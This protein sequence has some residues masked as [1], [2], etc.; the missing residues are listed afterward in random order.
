MVGQDGPGPPEKTMTQQNTNSTSIVPE[1]YFGH[2]ATQTRRP[3]GG[4][5]LLQWFNA[6]P[7]GKI[8]AT[9]WHIQASRCDEALTAALRARAVPR[10]TVLH[11]MSGEM[12]EYWSLET[13]SLLVLCNGFSDPWEMRQS[14][15]RD[16]I[17]YGWIKA[18]NSS[19]MKARVLVAELAV[20]GYVEPLTVTLEGTI[21]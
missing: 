19:K 10:I 16:G 5:P 20:A 14:S 12:V 11:R 1:G 2:Q 9:G 17:A 3:L 15:E 18:S 21:T 4:G 8:L 6:L 13:C 7:A